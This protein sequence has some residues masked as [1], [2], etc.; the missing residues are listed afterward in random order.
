MDHFELHSEYQPTGDQPR[1][2]KSWSKDSRRAISS[3]PYW[4]LPDQ[5]RP[6]QWRML[7]PG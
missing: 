2:L 3:R 5:V 6:S 1:P 7:S 4:V